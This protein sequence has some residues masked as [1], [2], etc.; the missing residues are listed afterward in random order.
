MGE[1]LISI[2]TGASANKVAYATEKGMKFMLTSPYCAEVDEA[3]VQSRLGLM[4]E[5]PPH[6]EDSWVSDLDG[7][8]LLGLSAEKFGGEVKDCDRKYEKS[9]YKILGLLAYIT[10]IEDVVAPI[11]LGVLLPFDE[12]ATKDRLEKML[13]QVT[14]QGFQFCNQ[15]QKLE[16]KNGNCS[17]G[18]N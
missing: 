3:T 5:W 7:T 18:V 10:E 13:G 1:F 17:T 8:Y 14:S 9:L 2:D 15:S 11:S 12:Y 16:L 4:D 6:F